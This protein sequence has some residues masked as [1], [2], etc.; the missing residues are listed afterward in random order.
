MSAECPKISIKLQELMNQANNSFPST[1]EAIMA[2]YN[3]ALEE[4]YTPRQAKNIL[5]NNIHFFDER[6]IRRY[7][8]LEAKD[9]EK[10]RTKPTTADNDP[11][12][13][14]EKDHFLSNQGSDQGEV[15]TGTVDKEENTAPDSNRRNILSSAMTIMKLENILK[16]KDKNIIEL[17]E[18]NEGLNIENR[19]LKE[20]KQAQ[21]N[22]QTN[23]SEKVLKVKANL[24]P[25]YRDLISIRDSNTSEVNILISNGKYIKLE[26]A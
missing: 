2:A 25:L 13:S 10:I 3:Q 17:L 7:L 6:T 16:N 24:S 9:T 15:I 18:R 26:P 1:G 11:Q 20:E 23:M 5:Y 21:I 22:S 19:K 14:P 4:G 12:K 8:P